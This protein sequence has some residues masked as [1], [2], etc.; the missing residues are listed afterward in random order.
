LFGHPGFD[1]RQRLAELHRP[2]FELT[3]HPEHVLGR[4]LLDVETDGLSRLTAETPAE[5]ER[6]SPGRTQRQGGE[7]ESSVDGVAGRIAHTPTVT[8]E[9]SPM[10]RRNHSPGGGPNY[11]AE[12]G[13][14]AGSPRW[15]RR[16]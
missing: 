2:A 6:G 10:P 11:A 14:T 15:C 12:A 9:A 7:L 3:Q 4:A 5:S 16:R 13:P 1:H 8:R